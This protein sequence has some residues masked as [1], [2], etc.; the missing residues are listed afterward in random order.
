MRKWKSVQRGIRHHFF[1]ILRLVFVFC[2]RVSICEK[3]QNETR[4]L[5][6]MRKVYSEC[7]VFCGVYRENIRKMRNTI[8]KN[9]PNKF[10]F[11]TFCIFLLPV[12]KRCKG[13]KLR[14]LLPSK[15]SLFWRTFWA[16]DFLVCTVSRPQ[17]FVRNV[18][19]LKS[20]TDYNS[21]DYYKTYY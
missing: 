11:A 20:G 10:E 18:K 15:I 16:R 4:N 14:I 7:F 8:S 13:W 19:V 17:I 9:R 6:E 2:A 12:D 3:S 21:H 1:H 5:D